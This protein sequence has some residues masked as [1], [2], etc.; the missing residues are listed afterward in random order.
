MCCGKNRTAISPSR[1]SSLAAR[2]GQAAP[3][4][5]P[6]Q[7]SSVAYFQYSGKTAMTVVGPVSGMR[8]R[9]PSSG[10]RLPVDIRDR[11][12]LAAVPGLVQV[13]GL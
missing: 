11:T 2:G 3:P 13:P 10:S 6:R 9:F 4:P 12:A 8:Y 1:T 7:R 5:A